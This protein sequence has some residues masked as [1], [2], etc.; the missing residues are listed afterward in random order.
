MKRPGYT[1]VCIHGALQEREFR[2]FHLLLFGGR[3]STHFARA[4]WLKIDYIDGFIYFLLTFLPVGTIFILPEY[5]IR[6][7]WILGLSTVEYGRIKCTHSH[8]TQDIFLF[9]KQKTTFVQVEEETGGRQGGTRRK[10]LSVQEML[11]VA[12]S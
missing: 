7:Y 5:G 11:A 4:Y 1:T 12:H 8:S 2:I 9:P 6:T 3:K 10:L